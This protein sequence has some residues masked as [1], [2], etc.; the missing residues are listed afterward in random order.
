MKKTVFRFGIYSL[1]TAFG[2]FALALTAGD[3][4]SYTTQEIIGYL[5]MIISL[6]F[7]FFGIRHY[8]DHVNQGKVSFGKALVIGLLIAVFAGIGIGLMDYIYTTVINPDFAQEYLNS[9]LELMKESMS[10]E[11]FNQEKDALEQQMEQYGGSGFMAFIMFLTVF[12]IGVII[13][14]ISALIL[15][16]K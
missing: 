6:S 4:L 3:G 14:V 8:R 15:Q 7:I 13:S 12:M 2:L 10:L 11:E 5:S 1:I 9:N 16:R